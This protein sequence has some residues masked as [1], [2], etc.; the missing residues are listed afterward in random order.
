MKLTTEDLLV[1]L[2]NVMRDKRIGHSTSL[3]AERDLY[4]L[5]LDS[6]P[7]WDGRT[8]RVIRM[9][10]FYAVHFCTLTRTPQ[11]LKAE[12]TAMENPFFIPADVIDWREYC[13]VCGY[14]NANETC[15]CFSPQ[16]VS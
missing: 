3:Q 10:R 9:G 5:H 11:G 7:G 14:P 1:G 15:S 16:E 12:F 13:E 4:L 8:T 6:L 2:Y